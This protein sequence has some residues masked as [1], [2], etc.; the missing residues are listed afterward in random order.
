MVIYKSILCLQVCS[1]STNR[2][3]LES[4]GAA[5]AVCTL[6]NHPISICLIYTH[7]CGPPWDPQQYKMQPRSLKEL[8]RFAFERMETQVFTESFVSDKFHA[9]RIGSEPNIKDDP[10]YI[11]KSTI[12]ESRKHDRDVSG[13]ASHWIFSM[14]GLQPYAS[15]TSEE[16]WIP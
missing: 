8:L 9:R 15:V 11:T 16:D 1:K 5:R 10:T 3:I 7:I 6:F 14:T 13:E 4:K 2:T 12:E